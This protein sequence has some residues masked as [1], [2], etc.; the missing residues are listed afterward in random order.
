M[1]TVLAARTFVETELSLS[2]A[3]GSVAGP[4]AEIPV[5]L[6]PPRETRAAPTVRTEAGAAP[7]ATPFAEGWP[8]VVAGVLLGIR[9]CWG[10][11]GVVLPLGWGCGIGGDELRLGLRGRNRC[12]VVVGPGLTRAAEVA[13][14]RAHRRDPWILPATVWINKLT[15]D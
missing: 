6:L 2:R 4:V 14:P 9:T 11:G 8:M 12:V 13:R 10:A 3:T 1:W 7:A 5:R 15:G